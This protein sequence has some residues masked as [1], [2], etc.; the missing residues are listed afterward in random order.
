[1]KYIPQ[2]DP[3]LAQD[4]YPIPIV[5]WQVPPSAPWGW[6]W[7]GVEDNA[8]GTHRLPV[9]QEWGRRGRVARWLVGGGTRPAREESRRS[10]P[11]KHGDER[12]E[13]NTASSAGEEREITSIAHS[14]RYY[15]C[16]LGSLK[17]YHMQ[18]HH[19]MTNTNVSLSNKACV[20]TLTVCVIRRR[21]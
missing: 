19:W 2:S 18:C 11:E 1:M 9:L 14:L 13:R 17:A 3:V 21:Q 12:M 10:A 20:L 5:H 6:R 4:N 8:G 15:H 16:C 7:R